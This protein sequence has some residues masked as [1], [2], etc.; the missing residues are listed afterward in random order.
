[1]RTF[2]LLLLALVLAASAPAQRYS[3]QIDP[4]TSE[5]AALQIAGLETDDAKKLAMYEDFIA[6]YPKSDGV[7]FA[8]GQAQPLMLKAGMFDK[9]ITGAEFILAVDSFNSVAAYY[10]LQACEQ[11]KDAGCITTWATRTAEAARKL[12]VS[13]KPDDVEEATWSRELDFAKQVITRCEYA[14]YAAELQSTNPKDIAMFYEALEKLSPTSQ[15]IKDAGGRYLITLLQA[16]EIAKAQD[17]AIRAAEN[18][19]A[20]DDVLLFAADASLSAKQ[21]YDKAIAYA[22]K[23]IAVLPAEP[24]PQGVNAAE[25][26]A[27]KKNSLGRAYWIQGAA[28]GAKNEWV[29]CE[30]AM[31]AAMPLIESSATGKELVPGAYF[32]LGLANYSLAKSTPKG[33]PVRKAEA[34]KNFQACVKFPGPFQEQA[35]KN[36]KLMAAGK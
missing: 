2:P 34:L 36:L 21:D 31:K 19:Q 17:F 22:G 15:Y 23:L 11:K 30:K 26:E 12:L 4:K 20:G 24:A 3:Y 13:K 32:Y 5:G 29:E 1:M 27:K 6:K 10:A 35:Q 28:Y 33:D 8:W 14:L 9:V 16:K 25:W 18:D 7:P